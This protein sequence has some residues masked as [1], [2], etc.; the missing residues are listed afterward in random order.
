MCARNISELRGSEQTSTGKEKVDFLSLP[1][2]LQ[3]GVRAVLEELA[4]GFYLLAEIDRQPAGQL[5]LTTQWSDWRNAFF[6]WIQSVYA[7]PDFRRRGVYRALDRQV[8]EMAQAAGNVCGIHPY[9][10]RTN[11]RTQQVYIALGMSLSY[12]NMYEEEFGG[13]GVDGLSL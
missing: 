5:L 4:P 2:T 11:Q 3:A 10:E 7:A 13:R 12:Y 1:D 9:V 8:R 6:W